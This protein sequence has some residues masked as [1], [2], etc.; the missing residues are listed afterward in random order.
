[1]TSAPRQGGQGA[2]HR[3]INESIDTRTVI[4]QDLT[5]R[6]AAR[7]RLARQ[8]PLTAQQL[9]RVQ[10]EAEVF[11]KNGEAIETEADHA[12]VQKAAFA[13]RNATK[14]LY[15]QAMLFVV[16]V[17]DNMADRKKAEALVKKWTKRFA[18]LFDVVL[19]VGSIP[20]WQYWPRRKHDW[21]RV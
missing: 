9:L 17:A 10:A 2:I 8:V 7:F 11:A 14:P 15:Q 6:V 5:A 13:W 20:D 12:Q 3:A 18:P 1:M 4:V 19:A 21:I 16:G